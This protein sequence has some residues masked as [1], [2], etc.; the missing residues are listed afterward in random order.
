[1][2]GRWH[3]IAKYRVYHHDN[4]QHKDKVASVMQHSQYLIAPWGHS[5]KIVGS[6][7]NRIVST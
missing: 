5:S 1:M 6:A 3:R 4:V 7:S 2:C